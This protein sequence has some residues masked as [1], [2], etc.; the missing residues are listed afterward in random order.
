MNLNFITD[1]ELAPRPREEIIIQNVTAHASADR[2]RV[3]IDI[4]ITPFAPSDKPNLEIVAVSTNKNL[5]RSLSIIETIHRELTL[6]MHLPSELSPG[7]YTLHAALYYD[8][9]QIQHS[10]QTTFQIE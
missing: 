5:I 8:P 3:K 2:Q 9:E 1:P 6:T 7:I 4:T 10:T